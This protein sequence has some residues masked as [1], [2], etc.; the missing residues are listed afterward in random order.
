VQVS[1]PG[2]CVVHGIAAWFDVFFNGTTNPLWLSTAPGQPVTHWYQIRCVLKSPLYVLGPCQLTGSLRLVAHNRQSY[3]VHVYL[4]GPSYSTDQ[5][6]SPQPQ[7]VSPTEEV[8]QYWEPSIF[9]LADFHL[10]RIQSSGS[11]DLKDPYYRQLNPA[12]YAAM[13]AGQG[14]VADVSGSYGSDLPV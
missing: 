8:S 1:V 7:T 11:F 6:K 9:A 5:S 13:S 3:I 12:L 4:E 2:P 10:V 14:T